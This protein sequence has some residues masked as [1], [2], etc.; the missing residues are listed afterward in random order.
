MF[1]DTCHYTDPGGRA[2]NEDSLGVFEHH[3]NSAWIVA[4]GLGGHVSGEEASA[5][6]VEVLQGELLLNHPV[7]RD[8]LDHAFSQM[9]DQVVALEGPLTT[10]VAA[11]SDSHTL[12]FANNGDSRLVLIR[13]GN[14]L[15]R[16]RDHSM[17]YV[18]YMQGN[19]AYEEIPQHPGQSRLIHA[20]GSETDFI[21]EHYDPITLE[22]GDAF[23]LCSDG[24]WELVNEKEILRA[25]KVTTD[26]EQWMDLCIQLLRERLTEHS[27]NYSAIFVR[28]RA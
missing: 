7:N 10:A 25:L 17:A 9:N 27:D 8:F 19:I 1:F 18:A 15:A 23:L 3:L 11:V 12:W 2:P 20:L 4:D 28:V 5:R 16:T 14:A 26:A 21:A 24:F 6:A 22:P 13:K